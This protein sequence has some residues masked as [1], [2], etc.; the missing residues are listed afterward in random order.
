MKSVDKYVYPGTTVLINKFNCKDAEKLREIEALSTG[1]NLAYLQLHPIKGDFDFKHLKEIHRFIFQDMY[2]WAGQSRT[3][4]IGKNNL[5]CRVQ[6]IDSYAETVFGDFYSSCYEARADWERFIDVFAKHY[7]D[8]NALHPFREGNGRAQREFARELCLECGYVFDLTQTTHNEMLE[9]SIQ[10]FDTGNNARFISIF[11]RNIIPIDEY[12][13]Y[14]SR[15]T[16]TLL[17]L[18]KDDIETTN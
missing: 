17:I 7:S 6:F 13:E 8:M 2:D 16:S 11:G 15:L 5:F 1:G 4:D 12:K 9:A 3:I 10:S 18:S 14:Q